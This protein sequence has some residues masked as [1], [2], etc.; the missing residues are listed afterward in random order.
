[1]KIRLLLCLFPLLQLSGKC[2]KPAE[3]IPIQYIE[4]LMF[5][6]LSLNNHAEPLFFMFDTGAAITVL[7]TEVSKKVNLKITEEAKIGTAGKT[8]RS[9]I[10]VGNRIHLGRQLVLDSVEIAVLGLS[11]LSNYFRTQI[12]GIIGTDI[13]FNFVTETNNDAG[14]LRLYPFNTWKPGKS[15]TAYDIIGLEAGHF[16]I[17]V[18]VVTKRNATPVSMVVK[19]D[20]GAD[21]ALTFHNTAVT[22]YHLPESVSKR[23]KNKQGFG[24]DSTLTHNLSSK[25][26]SVTFNR[27]QWRRVPV[28]FEVDPLNR[29]TERQ[30]DGLIGQALLLDFNTTYD[31]QEGKVYFENR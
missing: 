10:S 28:V 8:V 5:I 6:E 25:L 22:R 18:E 27:K 19:I 12:D 20:T 7:D 11:H 23:I 30:A 26:Y 16:G 14:E 1:M 2:Q 24:V 13:L 3:A 31:L 17:L 15:T 9:G 4:G 29:T 21:N